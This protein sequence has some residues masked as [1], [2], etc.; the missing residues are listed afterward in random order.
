M[1]LGGTILCEHPVGEELPQEVGR[2]AMVKCYRYG[3]IALTMLL[4]QGCDGV[5]KIGI[6]PG[7]FRSDYLGA[8]PMS[9]AM[10]MKDAT[11]S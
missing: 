11:T 3:K 8:V 5:M 6:Y 7:S 2:F 9:S 4:A 10:Q 1:N